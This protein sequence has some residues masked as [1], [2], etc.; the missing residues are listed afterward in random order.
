[1]RGYLNIA[2]NY[3]LSIGTSENMGLFD[4]KRRMGIHLAFHR[5]PMNIFLH[6]IFPVL[7]ALAILMMCYP[8]FMTFP[9]LTD[10]PFSVALLVLLA[11]FILYALVDVLAATL[12]CGPVLLLYPICQSSFLYFDQS[13]MAML[14][15][16]AGLFLF[17]L[18]V[19]VGIG[20]KVCESGLGDEVENIAEM[21]ESKNPIHFIILP[22]YTIL[23]LL[24]MMGYRKQ[25]ASIVWGI[26]NELRPKIV[27]ELNETTGIKIS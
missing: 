2:K 10:Q 25:Q 1:M 7:N 22:V 17:A 14:V 15:S 20:H 13:S 5:D 11:S 9:W 21:F 12:V 24:F 18:W 6:S 23:D 26:M 3:N 8:L 16:G 27:K 4:W 19:Q